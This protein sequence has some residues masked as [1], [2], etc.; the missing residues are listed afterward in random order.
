MASP[1][2][3]QAANGQDR[4]HGASFQ[5]RLEAPPRSVHSE[6]FSPWAA[7][8]TFRRPP[9]AFRRTDRAPAAA[10]RRTRRT[11]QNAPGSRQHRRLGHGPE[12][13]RL[14]TG[15]FRFGNDKGSPIPS[16]AIPSMM[17]RLTL[18]PIRRQTFVFPGGSSG[19]SRTLSSTVTYPSVGMTTVRAKPCP[20]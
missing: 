17:W 10:P 15:L 7:T 12:P 20:L 8:A 4:L 6:L 13:F 11:R 1:E 3:A 2:V 14:G 18:L 19:S 5:H 16:R 9:P